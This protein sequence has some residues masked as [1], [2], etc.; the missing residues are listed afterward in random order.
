MTK[1]VV[2]REEL[3]DLAGVRRGRGETIVFANGAFDLL[4]A[5]HVRYLQAAREQGDW[6][7]V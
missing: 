3:L 7:A 6:L 1:K 4:H 5:G 2:S